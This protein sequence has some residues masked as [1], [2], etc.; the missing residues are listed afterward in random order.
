MGEVLLS[1]ELGQPWSRPRESQMLFQ[2]ISQVVSK[3]K[4]MCCRWPA[5]AAACP[6]L[7]TSG[8]ERTLIP[9]GGL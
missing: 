7:Q 2:T 6:I 4:M 5:G 8:I 3:N 1:G 9:E